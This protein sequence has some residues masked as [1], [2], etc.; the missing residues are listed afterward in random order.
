MSETKQK[1]VKI[2]TGSRCVLVN[3]LEGCENCEAHVGRK[4]DM[5]TLQER[6]VELKRLKYFV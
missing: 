6:A 3:A 5:M 4:L 2:K 1:R